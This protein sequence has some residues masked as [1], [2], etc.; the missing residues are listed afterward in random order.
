MRIKLTLAFT[1]QGSETRE[2]TNTIESSYAA[3]LAD[4]HRL[5][6]IVSTE[7]K[8]AVGEQPVPKHN[9]TAQAWLK[10][11]NQPVGLEKYFD[12]Q[13]SQAM[14]LELANLILGAEANLKLAQMFKTLE[15]PQAPS[16]DDDIA[17]SDLHYL[18]SRKMGL[19]NQ[20][21]QGLIKVQDLVNRLLHESLG[22][23]LVDTSKPDWERSQLT[24][25]NVEEG[26]KTKLAAGAITQ[27]DF[28]AIDEALTIPKNA[29]GAQ[30]ALAYRN[31]LSHHIRPSVDY[32][33]FFST[34][35]SRLGEELRN[36][37]GKVIGRVHTLRARPPVQYQ[38]ADLYAAFSKYLDA[39]VEMLQKL[40][41][42][43]I[44]RR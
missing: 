16:F 29:P 30:T 12:V 42:V 10:F 13:N 17:V 7:L 35:E 24:R 9:S 1:D 36:P 44:L 5:A 19:L 22:G 32:P 4:E 38:F 11:P 33:M 20:S 2:E 28:D 40:S 26:L 37:Q 3:G 21:V 39:V 23:D 31:R 6:H 34:L 43:G 27:A 25:L 18:H 41:Q 14:W 8:V 15:P